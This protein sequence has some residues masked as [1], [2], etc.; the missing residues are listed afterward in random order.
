MV[1]KP[2][3]L[4]HHFFLILGIFVLAGC[5]KSDNQDNST[6][7]EIEDKRKVATYNNFDGRITYHDQPV[8]AY[9]SG[10]NKKQGN[11]NFTY[12]ADVK[13]P[14]P[15]GSKLSATGISFK[16]DKAFITY[17][18]NK[19]PSDYAGAIEV[20]DLKNPK[21][22]KLLAGIYFDDT[23][24]NE[25]YAKNNMVY[26]VG[27]R[28]LKHSGYNQNL[29]KGGVVEA[30]SFKGNQLSK[31]VTETWI[32]SYSANSILAHGN[33]LYVASGNTGGGAFELDLKQKNYLS[34]TDSDHYDHS[35]Y[36]TR[37]QNQ[38]IFLQGGSDPKLHIHN[39]QFNPSKKN[40]INLS[41]NITPV[42]GKNV[43]YVD[44]KLGNAYVSSGKNGLQVY[45]LGNKNGN[46]K[47]AFT[48]NG[49]GYVNGVHGDKNHIYAAKG[50][51][52]VFILDKNNFKTIVAQFKNF[53]GSANYVKSDN[54]NV[55][56]AHGKGGLKILSK[57]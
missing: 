56:I 1:K 44:H 18:W 4:R 2:F 31:S 32:P 21:K 51:E 9:D 23:D 41:T 6:A 15:S 36:V 39:S 42:D 45:D 28:S 52:G 40:V 12:I 16:A 5:E 8:A 19:N 54:K 50:G 33:K 27:G 34:I 35:K 17:H 7:P 14:S 55:F 37:S 46:V 11:T 38:Y 49:N 10:P 29:T 43:L 3:E 13:A 30:V 22:P 53:K 26:A 24:L 47:K 20:I 25:V 48:T 57:K